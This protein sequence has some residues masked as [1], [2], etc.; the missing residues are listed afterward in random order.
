MSKIKAVSMQMKALATLIK[1]A[2]L[3]PSLVF[4]VIGPNIA[5]FI[6]TPGY[7]TSV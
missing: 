4:D 5:N 6:S 1:A 3:S 2:S 7:H